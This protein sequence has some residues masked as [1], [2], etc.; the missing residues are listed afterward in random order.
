[1][2]WAEDTTALLAEWGQSLTI[3][4]A[5]PAYG[6]SGEPAATWTQQGSAVTGDIQPLDGDT[7]NLAAGDQD[8]ATHKILLPNGTTIRGG[9]RVRAAGWVTG[10]DE[11]HVLHAAAETPS[12]VS[13]LARLVRGHA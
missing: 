2:T 10:N 6:E 12:H 5:A 8:A 13:V 9:D 11:Y 4:R 7:P 3:A 1:M